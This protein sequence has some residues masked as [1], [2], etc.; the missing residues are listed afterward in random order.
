MESENMNE[1][2]TNAENNPDLEQKFQWLADYNNG[3]REMPPFTREEMIEI[4]EYQ[5]RK[6]VEL[7]KTF[8]IG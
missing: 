7:L 4:R 1:L 5:N 2:P 3:K 6:N 8:T